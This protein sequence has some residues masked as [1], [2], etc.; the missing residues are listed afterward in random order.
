MLCTVGQG[1][2]CVDPAS[3]CPAGIH[4]LANM[5]Q[6]DGDLSVAEALQ[7][8]Q[9]RSNT[10]LINLAQ[11]MEREKHHKSYKHCCQL[12]IYL[13][14]LPVTSAS[15]ER[16]HSKVDL[17]KSAVKSSMTSERS[18][19]LITISCDKKIFSKIPN[20]AIVARFVTV[21]RGLPL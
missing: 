19:S 6:L 10:S 3:L 9:Y 4:K 11:Q 12:V 18:E 2:H 5:A 13:L 15:C 7:L 1:L 20:L 16:S 14:T 21:P 8:A 17:I